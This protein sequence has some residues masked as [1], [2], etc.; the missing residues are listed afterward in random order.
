M[1]VARPSIVYRQVWAIAIS[2]LPGDTCI[3]GN[4][5][6]ELYETSEQRRANVIDILSSANA[7]AFLRPEKTLRNCCGWAMQN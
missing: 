6:K 4:I 2:S 7:V 3:L 1:S 5:E